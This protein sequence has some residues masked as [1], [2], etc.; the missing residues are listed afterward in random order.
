[1]YGERW[2]SHGK[3]YACHYRSCGWHSRHHS[4]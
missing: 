1:M 4:C 3:R 2:S